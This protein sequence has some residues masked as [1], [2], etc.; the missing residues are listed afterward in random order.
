MAQA[1][2]PTFV[3]I[4][5]LVTCMKNPKSGVKIKTRYLMTSG[6]YMLPTA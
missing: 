2:Y 1:N 4:T 6:R 3:G 5:F